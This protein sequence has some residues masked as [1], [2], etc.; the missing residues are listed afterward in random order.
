MENE[1]WNCNQICR[2]NDPSDGCI[3]PTYA[4]CPMANTEPDA[5][6]WE[7]VNEKRLIE[8]PSDG[9]ICIPIMEGN[10]TVGERRVDLSWY[11]TVDA[12]EV[13]RC[14]DCKRWKYDAKKLCG[15]CDALIC[16]RPDYF[17][18]MYGERKDDDTTTDKA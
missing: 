7:Q 5:S 11:P 6:G 1:K 13:I 9:I 17:W 18:C 10:T 16:Y 14:K 2:W 4:T 3:K 12:V 15:F 8:I